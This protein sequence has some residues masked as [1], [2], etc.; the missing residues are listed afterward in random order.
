MGNQQSSEQII[1]KISMKVEFNPELNIWRVI[2]VVKSIEFNNPFD[3][4]Y[5]PSDQHPVGLEIIPHPQMR[6]I[7]KF[8][9]RFEDDS[10]TFRWIY[11]DDANPQS[12]QV[13]PVVRSGR[14][15]R[16]HPTKFYI[17][18]RIEGT[19]EW[20]ITF[21]QVRD[22]NGN[23]AIPPPENEIVM[24]SAGCRITERSIIDT[25]SIQIP[26][27]EYD[28]ASNEIRTIQPIHVIDIELIY[29]IMN[30]HLQQGINQTNVFI[31]QLNY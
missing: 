9:I 10:T 15:L 16:N 2:F 24:F 31:N 21:F 14:R 8:I 22:V 29:E 28:A 30:H 3:V 4:L 13:L 6:D 20:V 17:C 1:S 23:L 25:G 11:M 5:F 19:T 12:F 7:K 26:E 27:L 18:D